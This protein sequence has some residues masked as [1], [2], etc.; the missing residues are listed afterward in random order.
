MRVRLP[1]AAAVAVAALTACGPATTTTA[2][3]RAAH[4]DPAGI[5]FGATAPG[6][7]SLPVQYPDEAPASIVY[8]GATYV[9][10]SRTAR[11]VAQPGSVIGTSGDW[12]VSAAGGDIY[13]LTGAAL[14]QYRPET[15]C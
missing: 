8:Q 10:T 5:T 3:W 1:V 4:P 9:Q 13:V 2:P 6:L 7:C 15:N 12:S 11:P 14:F